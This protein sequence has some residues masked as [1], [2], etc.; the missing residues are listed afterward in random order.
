MQHRLIRTPLGLIHVVDIL[1]EAGQVD[2]AEVRA[3]CRP[4]VGSRLTD[5][6]EARPEVLSTDEVVVLHMTHSSFVTVAPR[7]MTIVVG[8]AT[9]RGIIERLGPTFGPNEHRIT[10]R[11]V[12]TACYQAGKTFRHDDRLDAEVLRKTC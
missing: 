10:R 7:N 6:I 1:R 3:A 12:V 5:V 2:D 8:G 11:P 9:E 4:T